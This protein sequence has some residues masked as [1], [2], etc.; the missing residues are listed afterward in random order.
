[1]VQ[2]HDDFD[3]NVRRKVWAHLEEINVCGACG[4][5]LMYRW[6][7]VVSKRRT[8]RPMIGKIEVRFGPRNLPGNRAGRE[9]DSPINA[10]ARPQGF[11]VPATRVALG[12][13]ASVWP[14]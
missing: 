8:L 4:E 12:A 2:I 9:E 14:P 6:N 5:T 1:M 3:A 10:P 7:H 11:G 13:Y